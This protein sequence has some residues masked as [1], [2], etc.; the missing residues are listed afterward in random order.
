MNT[1]EQR[2]SM[3]GEEAIPKVL[4]KLALP[5]IMGMLINAIYNI[6]DTYFIGLLNNTS[7]IGAVSVVLPIFLLIGASGQMFGVGAAS[8]ISRLL[9][10]KDIA[11]AERTAATAFFSS[12]LWSLLITILGLIFLKPILVTFGATETILIYARDYAAVLLGGSCFTIMNM[13]LNNL[14]R[15]EGNARYS[16]YAIMFGAFLNIILDPLFIFYLGWGVRGAAYATVL[17]Q[18]LS[19]L[20]LICYYLKGASQVRISIFSFSFSRDIYSQIFRVG[21]PTLIRQSLTSLSLGFINAAASLYGDAALASIGISFRIIS[22]V[23]FVL[24]G[25]F[26]GFQPLASYNYGAGNMERLLESIRISL[27][28]TS[29]FMILSTVV[30]ASLAQPFLSAFSQDPEVIRIG[31]KTIR[32]VVLFFPFLGFQFLYMVLFQALGRGREALI[33]ALARQGLFLLPAILLL[34]RFFGLDG[35][36][37]SQPTADFLTLL[38]TLYLSLRLHRELEGKKGLWPQKEAAPRNI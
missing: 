27:L 4:W 1:R 38:V 18:G 17:A 36:I 5:A 30:L 11:R 32:A 9:G 8:Y 33:L 21:V 16:M 3:M 6:V 14:I 28:R 25:Y 12:L 35:V 31:V 26:Q 34:P 15:A 22:I 24:L 23:I 20:F 19:F 37:F 13:T 29:I 2:A 7:A 10:R